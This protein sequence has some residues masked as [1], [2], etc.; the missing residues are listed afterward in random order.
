MPPAAASW[1]QATEPPEVLKPVTLLPGTTRTPDAFATAV[2]V[3][4]SRI[5]GTDGGGSGISKT[6]APIRSAMS[7]QALWSSRPRTAGRPTLSPSFTS[8]LTAWAN[9]LRVPGSSRARA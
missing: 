8:G 2:R 4:F 6:G 3:R 1:T 7:L 5:P 9:R